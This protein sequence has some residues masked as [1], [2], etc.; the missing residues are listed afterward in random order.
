MR[1]VIKILFFLFIT[2]GL[3]G[4]SKTDELFST[5]GQI[6]SLN[7]L[8]S[9]QDKLKLFKEHSDSLNLG[10]VQ[11][12]WII[13][14]GKKES[15]TKLL[16]LSLDDK[17]F[18]HE[19]YQQRLNDDFESWSNKKLYVTADSSLLKRLNKSQNLK[20]Q[21]D[22]DFNQLTRLPYRSIFGFACN[23]GGTMPHD[24]MMTKELI[25][26]SDTTE[27][28][29]WLVSINPVRQ[30]YAY[31]GLK[32]LEVRDSITLRKEILRVMNELES[33]CKASVYSCSGCTFWDYLPICVQLTSDQTK[34]F[35]HWRKTE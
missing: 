20:Y 27:L 9:Q 25:N 11:T 33:T 2:T 19:F 15:S 24:G 17:I 14:K 28:E 6:K 8:T 34:S 1:F 26:K 13:K 18:Y 35:I 7:E 10:I 12:N 23:E 32:R 3:F 16:T 22:I 31:V 29:K 4:Q 30:A 21:T 5:V